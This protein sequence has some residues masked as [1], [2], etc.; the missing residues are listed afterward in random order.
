MALYTSEKD[1]KRTLDGGCDEGSQNSI[2]LNPR[3]QM[4]QQGGC[5]GNKVKGA[6]QTVDEVGLEG[7]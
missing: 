3:T 4:D 5:R 1:T 7:I 2:Y 6:I